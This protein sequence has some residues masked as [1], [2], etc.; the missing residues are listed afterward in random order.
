MIHNTQS[1]TVDSDTNAVEFIAYLQSLLA[2]IPES[3]KRTAKMSVDGLL[4]LW[5]GQGHAA[6]QLSIMVGLRWEGHSMGEG[7]ADDQTNDA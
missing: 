2:K 5:T 3:H 7:V 4:H 6:P 1:R